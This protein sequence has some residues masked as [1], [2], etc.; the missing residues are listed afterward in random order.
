M[1]SVEKLGE[2]S[3]VSTPHKYLMSKNAAN[4]LECVVENPDLRAT[5][6]YRK[7]G[8]NDYQGNKAKQELEGL[9]LIESTELPKVTGKG[10]Y[11]KVFRLTQQAE[12]LVADTKR[13][14]RKGGALHRHLINTL[15]RELKQH[16]FKVEVE[17]PLGLGRTTDIVADGEIAFEI[18]TSD[19]SLTNVTKN[20]NA[21]FRKVIL[22]SQTK[23]T[24]EKIERKLAESGS[25]EGVLVTDLSTLLGSDPRVYLQKLSER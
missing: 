5:E 11:G 13:T 17:V 22:V 6:H 21:G 1:A 12:H 10:R 19:F 23:S 4:L 3:D 20:L 25:T 7:V 9:G 15:A 8:L 24:R 16:G 2:T 14:K 18:E